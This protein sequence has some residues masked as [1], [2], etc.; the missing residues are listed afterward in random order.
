MGLKGDE[1][2]VTRTWYKV[3]RLSSF[4]SS[5]LDA[6]DIDYAAYSLALLSVLHISNI[7][8]LASFDSLV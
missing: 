2:I 1:K 5:N 6:A 3:L 7:S 8:S 4:A